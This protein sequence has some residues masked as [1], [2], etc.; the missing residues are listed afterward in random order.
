MRHLFLCALVAL[1]GCGTSPL[2]T[3]HLGVA[4]GTPSSATAVLISAD[5]R[6]SPDQR[7]FPPVLSTLSSVDGKRVNCDWNAG[8]PVW[9]R[10][11]PGDH[12]FGIHYRTDFSYSGKA[13]S[14]TDLNVEIKA[15]KPGH[16]YVTRYTRDPSGKTVSVR[17]EDLGEKANAGLWFPLLGVQNSQ[18]YVADF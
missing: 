15:M 1:G 5:Q 7:Y 16:V 4:P 9:I 6:Q 8:C 11:A 14:A 2:V 17:I 18:F 10:V 13:W 3:P 12:Q